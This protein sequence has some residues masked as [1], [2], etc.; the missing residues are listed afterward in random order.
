MPLSQFTASVALVAP[1]TEYSFGTLTPNFDFVS[2]YVDPGPAAATTRLAWRLYATAGGV[3]TLLAESQ[4]VKATEPY[5]PFSS[6]GVKFE[7]SPNSG[8]VLELRGVAYDA[9]IAGVVAGLVGYDAVV[10]NQPIEVDS[11]SGP[12]AFGT[13]IS[14][15]ALSSYHGRVQVQVDFGAARYVGSTWTL[16]G[17]IT[18]GGGTITSLITQGH[19]ADTLQEIPSQVVVSADNAG[20]SAY[21]V[22]ATL[23]STKYN[24][25]PIS[26]SIVGSD[27]KLDGTGGGG[28]GIT[29]LTQDVLAGP[30]SGSQ[31]ATVAQISRVALLVGQT[32]ASVS[33]ATQS[34]WGVYQ[35]DA[36]SN[37]EPYTGGA[38]F[39][40]D[41]GPL[42]TTLI[43][44]NFAGGGGTILLPFP[45]NP[46]R[47]LHIA[48]IGGT[49]SLATPLVLQPAG[50]VS[51]GGGAPGAAITIT[52]TGWAQ[53]L[54]LNS[55]G[56]NWMI[57]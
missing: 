20:A 18:G 52:T 5:R 28:G 40:C 39:A 32:T 27:P 23:T 45:A 10:N 19:V 37:M 26:A 42:A 8:D 44:C 16:Y 4:P 3:T 14:F 34:V 29:Q 38:A 25:L 54:V 51:I 11:N 12:L 22:R 35:P 43:E 48:D 21:L 2:A 47:V 31:A 57:F 6:V 7:G 49:I 55:L 53:K 33:S 17:Q 56:N 13:P 15:G 9:P 24:G 30:G 1:K 41:A 36:F 46:G 50:G